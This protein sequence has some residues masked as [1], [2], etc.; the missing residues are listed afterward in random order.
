MSTAVAV[1]E[2]IAL[3]RVAALERMRKAASLAVSFL[4]PLT[5]RLGR[6]LSENPPEELDESDPEQM[7]TIPRK[8]LQ[9]DVDQLDDIIIKID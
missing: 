7:E 4:T 3:E 1:L 6:V 8:A 2:R 5:N 9:A